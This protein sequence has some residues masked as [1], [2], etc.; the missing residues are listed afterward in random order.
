MYVGQALMAGY[1][2]TKPPDIKSGGLSFGWF[3][4]GLELQVF[5]RGG[6]VK[7]GSAIG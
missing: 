1:K 2:K 7:S 5:G 3:I 4:I 6:A